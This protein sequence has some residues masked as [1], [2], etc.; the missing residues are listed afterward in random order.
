MVGF[1]TC[2]GPKSARGELVTPTGMA[3]L[4]ALTWD[5]RGGVR[6]G[7]ERRKRRSDVIRMR[8]NEEL[9]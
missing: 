9:F 4:K 2:E 6:G 3:V 1:K 7:G 8:N 5:Y